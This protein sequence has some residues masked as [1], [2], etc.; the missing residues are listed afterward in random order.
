MDDVSYGQ[1]EWWHGVL[2]PRPL[3]PCGKGEDDHLA[4]EW[5]YTHKGRPEMDKEKMIITGWM[6]FTQKGMG[7]LT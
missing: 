1:S 7:E 3:C 2:L 4:A 5:M 6:E